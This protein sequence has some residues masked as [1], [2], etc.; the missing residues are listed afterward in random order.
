[1][2]TEL[3]Q[4]MVVGPTEMQSE[5]GGPLPTQHRLMAEQTG[6]AAFV[7]TGS[8]EPGTLVPPHVHEREDEV[9]YI[10][11]GEMTVELGTDIFK[12]AAGAVVWKPR[13]LRHAQWNAT[14]RAVRYFEV[15]TPAG[16]EGFFM[17][18]G[19]LTAAGGLQ[20]EAVMEASRKYGLDFDMAHAA[21][22]GA[23]FNLRAPA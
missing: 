22:L 5:V 9:T 7:F 6:G 19:R 23:Q 18:I 15:V 12:A 14:N 3:R 17:E 10:L 16:L 11:D 13:G 1:M 2:S 8:I 21:E 20:V 4:G